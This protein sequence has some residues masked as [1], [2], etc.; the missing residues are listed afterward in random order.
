MKIQKINFNFSKSETR[1]NK[2]PYYQ[3][4]FVKQSFDTFSFYGKGIHFTQDEIKE[5]KDKIKAALNEAIDGGYIL[6]GNQLSEKTGIAVHN[7]N[8]RIAQDDEIYALWQRV[9]AINNFAYSDE[10]KAEFE[11]AIKEILENA[12]KNNQKI[13]M[14][15]LDK[16]LGVSKSVYL[17]IIEENE[18][19]KELYQKVRK[20][21]APRVRTPDEILIEENKIKEVLLEAIETNIKK[22]DKEYSAELGFPAPL[23]KKRIDNNPELKA[24]YEQIKNPPRKTFNGGFEAKKEEI[25]E[26]LKKYVSQNKKIKAQDF[27]KE[28]NISRETIRRMSLTDKEF[29]SLW[30]Q[31]LTE[32]HAKYTKRDTELIDNYIHRFLTMKAEKGEKTTIEEIAQFYGLNPHY[33]YKRLRENPSLNYRWNKVKSTNQHYYDKNEKEF[34]TEQI[35][36]TLKYAIEDG[37]KLTMDDIASRTKLSACVVRNRINNSKRATKWWNENKKQ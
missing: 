23:F 34:Q 14:R 37:E 20:G 31:V 27:I 12:F 18:Y 30:K 11:N 13:S 33:T 9:K 35:I 6:T 3:N 15:E 5:Q 22:T 21:E 36:D 7:I 32:P 2:K 10:E 1:Y 8:S 4:F 29:A 24:L 28:A 26:V 19:Y 17:R 25:K 16:K